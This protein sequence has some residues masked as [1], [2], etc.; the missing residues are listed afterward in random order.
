ML[1]HSLIEH[2]APTLAGIKSGNLF[3]YRFER[4]EKVLME[5]A[6]MNSKL[7]TR[8]VYIEAVRWEEE[9][10]LIYVYRKSHLERELQQDGVHE[11]LGEYGY[12]DCEVKNCLEHLKKRLY[13]YECFPHEI[14]VFLGYPLEDVKGFIDNKGKDCKYSGLWKVYS[15]EQETKKL[16]E[17]IRKCNLVYSKVFASGRSI[18]KMTVNQ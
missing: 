16:F 13:E 6:E 9:A 11:L 12:P 8:G 18:I 5:L 7:N 2:C 15:N 3:R 14:G 10:V 4:K 1:E 17:K